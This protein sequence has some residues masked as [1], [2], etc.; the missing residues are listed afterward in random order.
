[1]DLVL[2][3][4][5]LGLLTGGSFAL[6]SWLQRRPS[7]DQAGFASGVT[8]F[9]GPGCALCGPLVHAL[10]RVGVEPLIV[11]VTVQPS[12]EIRSL[13]TVVVADGSGTVVLRRSGRAALIDVV[14]IAQR[15]R[16]L[17]VYKADR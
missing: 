14:T 16:E 7:P 4:L 6:V 3:L 10:N 12:P 13:P 5:L 2:R 15:S 9:T 11:D 17:G 8:V 1:M